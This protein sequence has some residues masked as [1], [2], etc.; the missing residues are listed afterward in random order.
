MQNSTQVSAS[1]SSW[2]L[3]WSFSARASEVSRGGPAL[4]FFKSSARIYRRTSI[5]EEDTLGRDGF[6]VPISLSEPF[7]DFARSSS[8]PSA[9]K[10]RILEDR[11]SDHCNVRASP[12][13]YSHFASQ[14]LDKRFCDSRGLHPF[15]LHK[16]KRFLTNQCTL[17]CSP[18]KPHSHLIRTPPA[19]NATPLQL[20]VLSQSRGLFCS[21]L[22]SPF[23]NRAQDASTIAALQSLLVNFPL[24]AVHGKKPPGE[25]NES[26]WAM[27]RRR[28]FS[29]RAWCSRKVRVEES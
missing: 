2:F 26:Q 11:S 27:L 28:S 3:P 1:A 25:A 20:R 8:L 14:E 9:L 13:A 19:T 21:S 4:Y 7:A 5:S 23:T 18:L 6:G 10:R 12:P 29:E 16:K 24:A 17:H 15:P 22:A